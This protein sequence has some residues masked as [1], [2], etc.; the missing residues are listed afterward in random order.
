MRLLGLN[1]RNVPSSRARAA[2]WFEAGPVNLA[3]QHRVTVV[4]GRPWLPN[5]SHCR[6]WHVRE[7]VKEYLYHVTALTNVDTRACNSAIP[8]SE[9]TP[10][11]PILA[12]KVG[13]PPTEI[14]D[15]E[16]AGNRQP[17]TSAGELRA[18]VSSAQ[19]LISSTI[20]EAKAGEAQRSPGDGWEPIVTKWVAYIPEAKIFFPPGGYSG[21]LDKPAIFFGGDNHGTNNPNSSARF[22]QTV[23][24]KWGSTHSVSYAETMGTT[25]KYKCNVTGSSCTS[26]G[27]A[28]APLSQLNAPTLVSNAT[29]GHAVLDAEAKNPLVSWAPPI[30]TSVGIYLNTRYS[31]VFGYH[32][33]MPRHEFYVGT[34]ASEYM[35]VYDSDYFSAGVQL[36]CLYSSPEHPIPMCAIEFN[37][38]I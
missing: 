26:L 1:L 29:S 37:A 13:A 34:P 15:M 7:V 36:G 25:T 28:T 3:R 24:W 23:T 9:A 35:K 22:T 11:E 8:E 10:G 20:N 21:D 18:G 33:N 17:Q 31:Y 4:R 5:V 6:A 30:D 14:P 12:G 38:Q 2:G 19:Q 16:A 27:S 32:D